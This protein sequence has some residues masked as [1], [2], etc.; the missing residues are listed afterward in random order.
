MKVMPSPFYVNSVPVDQ[1]GY[2]FLINL[3]S[4]VM[5]RFSSIILFILMLLTLL[6]VVPVK[7]QNTAKIVLLAKENNVAPADL[8]H[9]AEIIS[10]RLKLYGITKFEVKAADKGN[11]IEI[12]LPSTTDME[13]VYGLLTS[14][15]EISFYETYDQSEIHN[16][17]APDNQ[18]FKILDRIDNQKP[19]DPRIGSI[20]P[21]KITTVN[22]YL[23]SVSRPPD[24]LFIWGKESREPV[25]CLF[26]LKTGNGGKALIE[27]AEINSV[28]ASITGDKKDLRIL[29]KLNEAGKIIFAEA[30]KR[31][32]NK[33]IAIVIDNIVYSWPV[34]RSEISGGEIEISGSFTAN[35]VKY[36]PVLFN[37]ERLPLDFALMK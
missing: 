22:N 31:D 3:K 12:R 25:N 17:L 4:N 35:E 18:I 7:S 10:T 24:C 9:S 5:K 34:V 16:L 1:P 27:S 8:K 29:I 28:K 26:A 19:S 23:G 36:L 32:L 21:D 37:S 14:K 30:T 15:G 6:P 2:Y 33:S 11:N 20:H 13:A